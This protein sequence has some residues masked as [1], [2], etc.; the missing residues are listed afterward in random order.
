MTIKTMQPKQMYSENA[1]T[2]LPP[3][4]QD[5]EIIRGGSH[6]TGEPSWMLFDPI[7]NQY[8]RIGRVFFTSLSCWKLVTLERVKHAANTRLK[9]PIGDEDVAKVLDFLFDNQL[10]KV[11][12]KD[13]YKSYL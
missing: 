1:S 12:P 8:Y 2:T 6:H 13:G 11:P 4:R 10:T 3:L 7:R 5:L 9:R